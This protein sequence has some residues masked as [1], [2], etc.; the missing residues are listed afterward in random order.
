VTHRYAAVSE[1]GQLEWV[2]EEQDADRARIER[3]A[4]CDSESTPPEAITSASHIGL[5]IDCSV[6]SCSPDIRLGVVLFDI[7]GKAVFSTSPVDAGEPFPTEAGVHR[8]RVMFPPAFLMPQRYSVNVSLYSPY[9]G[10]DHVQ[11]AVVIDVDS[12]ASL[13]TSIDPL[14]PGIIQ[15]RCQW[16]HRVA[17]L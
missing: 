15:V 17:D 11:D 2:A 8:Y 3:V 7:S 9:V 12:A 16:E 6:P 10:I 14:R 13:A 1:Q 5:E 4:V